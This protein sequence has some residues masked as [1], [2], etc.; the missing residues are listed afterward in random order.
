MRLQISFTIEYELCF[1]SLQTFKRDIDWYLDFYYF[2][3]I[4]YSLSSEK[5]IPED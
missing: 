3:E 4:Y 1:I 5:L 2:Q